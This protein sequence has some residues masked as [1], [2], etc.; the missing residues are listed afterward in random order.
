MALPCDGVAF[1]DPTAKS[2]L[3]GLGDRPNDLSRLRV[4]DIAHIVDGL[5]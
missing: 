3:F 4:A 2:E 5:L 1:H